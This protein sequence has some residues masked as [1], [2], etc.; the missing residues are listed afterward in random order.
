MTCIVFLGVGMKLGDGIRGKSAA[1]KTSDCAPLTTVSLGLASMVVATTGAAAQQAA[2]PAPLP[3][4]EVTAKQAKAK[5]K[6]AA[7]KVPV[8]QAAPAPAEPTSQQAAEPAFGDGTTLTPSTGNSLQS[9]TGI[10]RLQGTL[11]DTPQTVNVVT[12][13]EMKEKGVNTVDQALRAVPGVTVNVGEGGGGM[14]GDQFRIRGFQAKSDVYVDGLRDFGVY[15]RDSFAVEQVEVFKGP[16]SESFGGGTTGGA[17]NL[18]QKTAHLGDSYNFEAS[19]GT[20][21]FFRTMVDVNKQINATTAARAVALYHD[22]NFADR[23]Y[24]Y[25]ERFGFLGSLAFG[26]GTDTK[27]TVNYMHQDG[28]RLP[29]MGVPIIDPDGPGG[30]RQGRPVTEFGIDRTN[31]YGKSTDHDDYS[32]D[33]LTGRLTIY[34][35]TRLA[36]YSRDYAQTVST[37]GAGA[38][39]NSVVDG[40]FNGAYTPGGPAG[41]DQ[42]AWGAQN[43]T[44]AVAKFKTAGLRHELIA[45]LDV[46]YQEDDRNQKINVFDPGVT[47]KNVGTIGNPIFGA[48]GYR[49]ERDPNALK[50][51]DARDVGVFLSD[52]VWLTDT[53]SVLGGIRYDD[54]KA[55]Y[56]S[57][58]PN[59]A[60]PAV[61]ALCAGVAQGDACP[62]VDTDAQFWSPKVS[63]MW[64]P[65][66]S[67]SYYASWAKSYTP[68]GLYITNDNTSVPTTGAGAAD[69]EENELWEIGGKWSALDGK[70]GFSAALFRVEKSNASYADLNGD[71]AFTGEEQRVQGV[72]LGMSGS[73]TDYWIVQAAYAYFDSEILFNPATTG[74]NAVAQNANKGNRVSFVPENSVSLWTSYEI[75]EFVPVSG[76]L[77]VGGGVTYSDG[78]FVNS[79]NTSSIPS[80]ITFD[81]FTSYEQDGWRFALNGYNLSDELNYDAAIGNRAVVSP[82]RSAVFTVGKK[83]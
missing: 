80:N 10:G 15:V 70:L 64:E 7:K 18:T 37:C 48:I 60:P 1:A 26:L 19:V 58:Q 36:W 41:W 65:T 83:F 76:K 46:Y 49:V 52:R 73:V 66:K 39:T 81:A 69:P 14:N 13:R 74:N 56:S 2:E 9:G 55:S 27:L 75:S 23:D 35:D 53:F 4:L 33:M 57:T 82:G 31:F 50:S 71:P 51:A 77:L 79:G 67:Q 24:L 63:L 38:C 78:Y 6:S 5:K 47:N 44:T 45:G 42:D 21:D 32:V 30:P 40:T 20:D 16:T 25:S 72:E 11:Q 17:I 3:A 12:Q 8:Q 68:Q 22:Q 43:I 61:P 34:N 29:D 28:E 59:L 62:D 54:Y